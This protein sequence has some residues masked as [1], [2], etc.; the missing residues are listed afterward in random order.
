MRFSFN[1][2]KNKLIIYGAHGLWVAGNTAAICFTA[3]LSGFFFTKGAVAA[4]L[5]LNKKTK[6]IFLLCIIIAQTT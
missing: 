2:A 6:I 3:Y 1:N 4:G 5:K